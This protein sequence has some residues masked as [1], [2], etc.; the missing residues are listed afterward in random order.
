[1]KK[2]DWTFPAPRAGWLGALDR[3][4]GPG[5]TRAELVLQF[6]LPVVAVAAALIS[7]AARSVE[8]TTVQRVLAAV[9][10]ADM[11]GGVFTNATSSA[12]RW[13]HRAEQGDR[14][15]LA[16][17]GLHLIHLALVSWVFLDWQWL[18]LVLAGSYLFGAAV[19][20]LVTPLYLERPVALSLFAGGLLLSQ[21]VLVSPA[22]IEWFLPLFYLKL[23]VSHL[24]MEEPYRPASEGRPS[25][26]TASESPSQGSLQGAGSNFDHRLEGAGS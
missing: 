14:H 15:H 24:P 20:V 4:I 23:L 17:V 8:W 16:F 25:G 21:F 6:V 22:G 5:A 3:F 26:A 9:L 1:M 13:Y 18:W 7:A 10:A 19:V 2:I 11:M 12:K